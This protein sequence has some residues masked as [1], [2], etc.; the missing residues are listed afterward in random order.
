MKIVTPHVVAGS[1]EVEEL[2]LKVRCSNAEVR[3]NTLT[4]FVASNIM[5]LENK[6]K[7]LS[8]NRG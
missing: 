1:S 7:I 3:E 2:V 8:R 6:E 4:E 5:L